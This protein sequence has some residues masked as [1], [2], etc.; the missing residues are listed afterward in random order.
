M[1]SLE[2]GSLLPCFRR[3]GAM[4]MVGPYRRSIVA[5]NPNPSF[6]RTYLSLDCTQASSR[7]GL[8]ANALRDSLGLWLAPRRR[9]HGNREP[10]SS[11]DVLALALRPA[12]ELDLD[13]SYP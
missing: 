6:L 10:H 8:R 9:K 2:C 12:R 7:A 13:L 4:H 1:S 5:H 11:D 3:R